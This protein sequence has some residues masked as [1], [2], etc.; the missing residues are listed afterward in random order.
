MV[1]NKL[2]VASGVAMGS[3]LGVLFVAGIYGEFDSL[4]KLVHLPEGKLRNY[5]KTGLEGFSTKVE[6][7]STLIADSTKTHK[8]IFQFLS[9][10]LLMINIGL[11]ATAIEESKKDTPNTQMLTNLAIAISIS[12][13]LPLLFLVITKKAFTPYGVLASVV[14]ISSLLVSRECIG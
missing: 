3:S 12:G 4:G 5:F 14:A 1:N 2:R 11:A 6:S 10:L 7:L 13:G 9:L 8:K